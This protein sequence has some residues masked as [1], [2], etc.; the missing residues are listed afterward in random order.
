MAM[1]EPLR[2]RLKA[3]YEGK[4]L[5][6]KL[7]ESWQRA[8]D[9]LIERALVMEEYEQ[10]AQ[11]LPERVLDSELASTVTE[12]FG[13]DRAAFFEALAESRMTMEEWRQRAKESIVFAVLRRREVIEH[14]VVPPRLVREQYEARLEQYRL[15]EQVKLRMIALQRGETEQDRTVKL[16]EA[17]QIRSRLIAGED[18]AQIARS[19]SEGAKADQGGDLG[20]VSPADL[21]PEL[22]SVARSLR[23]GTISDVIEAGQELYLLKV[24][25]RKDASVVP[26]DEARVQIEDDLRKAEIERLHKAW[27]ERLKRKHY[28]KVFDLPW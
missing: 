15:P 18:F 26:F 27:I 22:S 2:D 7:H 23:A 9:A 3:A 25:A 24:E 28:V 13:N 12:Q 17:R 20:W 14:V 1:I 21:R 5:E 10:E 11:K 8:L 16:D 4:E 6:E 19:A